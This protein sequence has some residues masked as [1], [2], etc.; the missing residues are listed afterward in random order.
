MSTGIITVIYDICVY[1]WMW[2]IAYVIQVYTGIY[3]YIQVYTCIPVYIPVYLYLSVQICRLRSSLTC[4]S[5]GLIN[6]VTPVT[7]TQTPTQTLSQT[8]SLT[9]HVWGGWVDSLV[10]IDKVVSSELS[11][12]ELY[13]LCLYI[14]PSPPH[15]L[16]RT[17][18]SQEDSCSHVTTLEYS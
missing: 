15:S 11:L 10:L 7:Q 8:L 1:R 13:S 4:L 18:T 16:T 14:S 17:C 5:Q 12:S 9:G 6:L 3:R 2:L